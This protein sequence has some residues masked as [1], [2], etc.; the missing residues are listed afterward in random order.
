MSA[1]DTARRPVEDE[2]GEPHGGEQEMTT[3]TIPRVAWEQFATKS[4]VALVRAEVEVLRSEVKVHRTELDGGND[5][6]IPVA[7]R[8]GPPPPDGIRVSTPPR[9]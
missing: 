5:D 6:A 9:R 2:P 7:R 3:E 4:D 8:P 1:A